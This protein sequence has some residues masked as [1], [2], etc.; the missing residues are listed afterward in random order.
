MT[1]FEKAIALHIGDLR[2]DARVLLGNTG[3][4]DDLA[5]AV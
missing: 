3:E 2:R 4:P 1:R 5:E